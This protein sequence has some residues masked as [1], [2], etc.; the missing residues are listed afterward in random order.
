MVKEMYGQFKDELNAYILR[1]V[2]DAND[3]NDILQ[4]S[5][6]KIINN[7]DKVNQAHNIKPYLYKIVIH[8]ISDFYRK[9]SSLVSHEELEDYDTTETL[10]EPFNRELAQCL[11]PFID[12]LPAIYKDAL[13]LSELDNKSQ[14]E[15]A[16]LLNIPYSSAK[17]RVQRGR[18]KLKELL[19]ACCTFEVDV[20]G[21]ILEMKQNCGCS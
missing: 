20:Y 6:V 11:R 5:F 15:I 14:K 21:N 4:D 7:I 9:K 12:V 17:S 16:I 1:K 8:T 18:Q 3:A 10:D 13:I 2:H 19:L